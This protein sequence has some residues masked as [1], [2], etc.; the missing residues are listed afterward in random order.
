MNGNQMKNIL[1]SI[2]VFLF[3]FIIS[4][5]V[6]SFSILSFLPPFNR[7]AIPDNS[8]LIAVVI[9]ALISVLL[10]TVA[11]VR[12]YNKLAKKN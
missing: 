7:V 1:I 8:T 3:T 10:A 9:S 11:V 6:S 5:C 4:Y 12:V 2:A